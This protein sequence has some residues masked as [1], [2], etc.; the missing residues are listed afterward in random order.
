MSNATRTVDP[1]TLTRE[2]RRDRDAVLAGT[3]TDR[4]VWGWQPIVL[5]LYD[6]TVDGLGAACIEIE[7]LGSRLNLAIQDP[8][9]VVRFARKL[10]APRPE[11]LRRLAD[12]IG[13]I[14]I[15]DRPRAAAILRKL[16]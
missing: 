1:L 2:Q 5:A 11:L 10:G 8:A 3:M 9:A 16:R 4:I 15:S 14:D 12:A 6:A 7:A 13:D